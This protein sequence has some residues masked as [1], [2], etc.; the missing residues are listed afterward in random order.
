MV[1]PIRISSER[2]RER[3]VS[4]ATSNQW[5][6]AHGHPLRAI[7]KIREMSAPS[8]PCTDT[9]CPMEEIVIGMGKK[10]RHR[11]V[12]LFGSYFFVQMDLVSRGREKRLSDLRAVDGIAS[13]LGVDANGWPRPVVDGAVETLRGCGVYVKPAHEFKEGQSIRFVDGPFINSINSI[14]RLD[15]ADRVVVLMRILGGS[16]P[17]YVSTEH[18]E[19]VA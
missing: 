14:L 5:F 10:C 18:I 9:Y 15:N 12:P 7:R 17:V 11:Q 6:V 2:T 3:D 4:V 16:V 1:V 19:A 13:L 8:R